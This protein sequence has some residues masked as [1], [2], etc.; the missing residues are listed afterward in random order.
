MAEE[1][2][3]E[4]GVS[5]YIKVPIKTLQRWRAEKTG[6][7]FIKAGRLVRYRL[8]DVDEWMNRQ[9]IETDRGTAARPASVVELRHLKA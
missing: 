2:F 8:K 9:T 4:Q 5:N 3:N 6:P 7:R 1:V